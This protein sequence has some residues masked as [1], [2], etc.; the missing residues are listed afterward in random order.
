MRRL[1]SSLAL[2]AILALGLLW[3]AFSQSG[4]Q[5]GG[6]LISRISGGRLVIEEVTGRLSGPLQIGELRWQ[7][8][9]LQITVTRLNIDWSPSE[10]LQDRLHLSELSAASVHIDSTPSDT[11]TTIPQDLSLP[12]AVDLEKIAIS[13]LR[14]GALP[15]IRQ[16][17]G[18]LQSDGNQH[19]LDD[20]R[21]LVA[22]RHRSDRQTG[23]EWPRSFR[24]VGQCG[25]HRP[26]RTT[27]AGTATDG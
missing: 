1:L 14:Y 12:V 2:F 25:T 7:T 23:P 5:T 10:L 27:S 16:I 26:A 4:A 3:L 11:P 19:Q 6:A 18:R 9:E 15:E 8:P 17:T 13:S 24:A 20:F 21:A 22:R